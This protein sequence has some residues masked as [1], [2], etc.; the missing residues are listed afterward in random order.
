M[1]Y[2]SPLLALIYHSHVGK[3][4]SKR[5]G[6]K[7]AVNS[8]PLLYLV[9]SYNEAGIICG[10]KHVMEFF[11]LN[12]KQHSTVNVSYRING[13]VLDGL[14]GPLRRGSHRGCLLD[15]RITALGSQVLADFERLLLSYKVKGLAK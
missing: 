7:L 13:L 2:S 6:L 14:L 4:V 8:F 12:G 3:T 1:A 15:L 10:G 9:K 5:Y 11:T